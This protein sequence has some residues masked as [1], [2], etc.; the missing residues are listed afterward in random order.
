MTAWRQAI[1]LSIGDE[2]VARCGEVGYDNAVANGAGE[3]GAAGAD[4]VGLY[5]RGPAKRAREA[6]Q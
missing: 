1:E 4:A 5:E 2:D 3:P 6:Q